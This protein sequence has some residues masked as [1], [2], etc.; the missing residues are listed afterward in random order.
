MKSGTRT[1]STFLKAPDHVEHVELSG[2]LVGVF[3]ARCIALLERVLLEQKVELLPATRR[4]R[5]LDELEKDVGA[6]ECT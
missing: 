1:A 4:G 6:P 3:M 2:G 5:R